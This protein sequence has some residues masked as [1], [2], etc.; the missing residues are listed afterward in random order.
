ML[1]ATRIWKNSSSSI[2]TFARIS[3][4]FHNFSAPTG[5]FSSPNHPEH[6]FPSTRC[7]Y[8]ISVP[9]NQ[10]IV[11][12]ISSFNL[13]SSRGGQCRDFVR[14]Q[15]SE[16]SEGKTICGRYGDL[17]P[18]EASFESSSNWLRISFV[19]DHVH[20]DS[21]FAFHYESITSCVNTTFIS[22][23]GTLTSANY[24][25]NYLNNQQCSTLISTARPSHVIYLQ[26][27]RFYT[28]EDESRSPSLSEC[29]MDY[30]EISDGSSVFR[31]CGNWLGYER[32]LRFRSQSSWFRISFVSDS[33]GTA[34]G[35]KAVWKAVPND[36]SEIP[37]PSDWHSFEDHCF[38]VRKSQQLHC[39]GNRGFDLCC[40]TIR[41]V[42]THVHADVTFMFSW[43]VETHIARNDSEN[44]VQ[45]QKGFCL[46]DTGNLW[47]QKIIAPHEKDKKY[48]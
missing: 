6:Y 17:R 16:E 7:T 40:L 2:V 35:Y 29:S 26:F 27:E 24:P 1:S 23:N 45:T 43:N 31:R 28:L 22:E 38:Q 37:C 39:Y 36:T 8:E 25:N 42:L 9:E 19:S 11:L 5:N 18:D 3:D 10:R 4:C 33:S 34:S 46:R 14:V 21:G 20:Q 48:E 13:E 32:E 41:E 30:V 47:K 44:S 12:R 15:T